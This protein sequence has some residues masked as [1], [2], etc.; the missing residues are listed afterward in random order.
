[1][2]KVMLSA[3]Y[4]FLIG[5]LLVPQ[6]AASVSIKL[7]GGAFYASASEYN[8]GWQGI[9]DAAVLASFTGQYRP[10]HFGAG[11]GAEMILSLG[12]GFGLGFGAGWQRATSE[13]TLVSVLPVVTYTNVITPSIKVIPLVLN[14]HYEWSLARSLKLDTYAGIGYCLSTFRQEFQTNSD[15]LD[16]REK[17]VFTAHPS[18]FSGQAG[19]ALDLE[20]TRNIG[21]FIQAEGRLATLTDIQG[22]TMSF[23]SYAFGSWTTGPDPATLWAY[24]LT[25]TPKMVYPE[26]AVSAVAPSRSGNEEKISDVRKARFDLN[27]ASLSA[28]IRI[29]L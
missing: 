20:I 5:A 11:F 12:G 4:L 13:S 18:A 25:V 21:L 14:L 7:K 15:Y 22:E 2:K 8:A 10:V 17:D 19:I 24:T 1:M 28:G 3:L 26:I 16:S 6:A 23:N 27:G 29:R 9:S